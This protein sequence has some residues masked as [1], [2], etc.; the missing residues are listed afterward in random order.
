MP[1]LSAWVKKH[2]S[3]KTGP[4][5]HSKDALPVLPSPR[6]PIT[7]E[8][9]ATAACLLFQL[10]WDVRSLILSIAFGS[11]TLH[12]DLVRR[13]EAWQW[14]GLVCYQNDHG[15]Q[16]FPLS[17]WS[18]PHVWNDPCLHH[19]SQRQFPEDK[20]GVMGFLLSCRQ[21]Y[22]EGIDFLYAANCINI[23]SEP[24]LLNLPRI[25]AT[26]RLESMTS[27]EI[28]IRVHWIKQNNEEP[29]LNLDHLQPI[30]DNIITHC[31]SLRSFCLAFLGA[32]DKYDRACE[33]LDG[34]ALPMVDAFYR[35]K[36]LRDMRVELPAEAYKQAND[37]KMMDH[38]HEAPAQEWNR[39]ALWR[40]LDGEEPTVQYR[41]CERYPHPPLKLP[42]QDGEDDTVE[43][44][45]YWFREGDE[46][47]LRPYFVCS[48]G[49]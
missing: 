22:T 19:E 18:G 43:S 4:K 31:H 3:P 20:V 48:I 12:M 36:L 9:F 10:P 27:L 8:S 42:L 1:K 41:S 5:K 44:N 23:Q 15:S 14:R 29:I 39:R 25:I 45:G 47:P 49:G 33:I 17:P 40:C 24:L 16:P 38:P 35:S 34:L 28:V 2:L 6:R 37:W 26:N 7:Q 11:R 30:L 32:S 21:A 13:D 46:G